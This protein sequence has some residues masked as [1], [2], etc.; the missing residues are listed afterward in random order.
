MAYRAGSEIL[1]YENSL[2]IAIHSMAVETIFSTLLNQ[3]VVPGGVVQRPAATAATDAQ[4]AGR[5]AVATEAVLIASDM[6][7]VWQLGT[8]NN[9]AVAVGVELDI[10]Q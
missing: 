4:L 6:P 7:T 1:E 2:I 3:K 5:T 8:R 9:F 10:V